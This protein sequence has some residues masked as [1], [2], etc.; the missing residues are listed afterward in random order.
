MQLNEKVAVVGQRLKSTPED[1]RSMP[2]SGTGTLNDGQVACD[3]GDGVRCSVVGGSLRPIGIVVHQH[4]GKNGADSNGKEAYQQYDVPPI[5]R[6]GRIWVKPAVPI[7]ATG[8]KVYV[9]TANATTNNPLG[10]YQTS[11]TDGTELVGATWDC[12]S[13]ADGMAIVQLRGA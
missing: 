6:V 2:M 1:V 8:G 4:I 12:I 5:M 7:T 13:N 10:S 9:R 3:A 11:A